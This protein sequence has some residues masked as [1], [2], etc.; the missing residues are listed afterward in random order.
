MLCVESQ[1]RPRWQGPVEAVASTSGRAGASGRVVGARPA[2]SRSTRVGVV[3]LASGWCAGRLLPG[4][5]RG[6]RCRFPSLLAASDF[7]NAAFTLLTGRQAPNAAG[8]VTS[9]GR[10]ARSRL[11]ACGVRSSA[12]DASPLRPMLT[13]PWPQRSRWERTAP[14]GGLRPAPALGGLRPLTAS[15]VAGRGA[16]TPR[17]PSS[18][19]SCSRGRR[20]QPLRT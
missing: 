2:A 7:L 5:I 12:R 1:A 20:R 11:Q 3:A 16:G 15:S 6:G 10:Q 18:W 17:R 19:G 4:R 13:L 9:R 8:R 14:S